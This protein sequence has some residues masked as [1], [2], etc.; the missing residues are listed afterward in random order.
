MSIVNT[1]P[2]SEKLYKESFYNI[3]MGTDKAGNI[4]VVNSNKPTMAWLSPEAYESI[5]GKENLKASNVRAKLIE[6]GFVVE[7]EH[8]ELKRIFTQRNFMLTSDNSPV[9]QYVIA[10]TM[11]CN[12]HCVYCF[13]N[14]TEEKRTMPANMLNKVLDT[15]KAQIDNCPNCQKIRLC[16]FGGEPTLMT[17]QIIHF[18]DSLNCFLGKKGLEIEASIISNGLLLN[19]ET[20]EKFKVLE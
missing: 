14:C 13:E 6:M 5:K 11:A 8:D 17:G 18:M 16:W 15:I 1:T 9:I 19:R 20:A 10:P 7:Q 4:L 3:P 2:Q 12:M